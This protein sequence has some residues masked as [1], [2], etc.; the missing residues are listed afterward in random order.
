MEIRVRHI[1]VS[2]GHNFF[3]HYGKEPG[4]HELIE[5]P[6]VH[7]LAGRGLEGD[8]FFDFKPDYKGQITFFAWEEYERL[9]RLFGVRDRSPGVFRRNVITQGVDLNSLIGREFEIQGVR[10]SGSAECTPCSWMDVA[11]HP[12]SEEALMGVGGLRARILSDGWVE[13]ENAEAVNGAAAA[14]RS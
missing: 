12:G 13:S 4:T 8:R 2:P 14:V 10:F 9:S 11:F 1:Y 3:G 5:V 7:C 6:R